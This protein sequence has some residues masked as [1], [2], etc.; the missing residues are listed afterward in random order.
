M[1]PLLLQIGARLADVA[2]LAA[3]RPSLAGEGSEDAA[4]ASA[5]Q[6]GEREIIAEAF[7]YKTD[8]V[9][10]LRKAICAVAGLGHI[11][12]LSEAGEPLAGHHTVEEAGLGHRSEVRVLPVSELTIATG[13]ADCDLRIWDAD[14]GLC[15]D[16]LRAHEEPIH[17]T[18]FSHAGGTLATASAD[19]TAK[20]WSVEDRSSFRTLSDH[21]DWVQTIVFSPDDSKLLTASMDCSAKLWDI[22]TG[23]CTRTVNAEL[24]PLFS[25]AFAPCGELAVL[26]GAP[27]SNSAK[28]WDLR[29]PDGAGAVF[30]PDGSGGEHEDNVVDAQF[31]M[32]GSKVITGSQD[33]T[34]KLWDLR[35]RGCLWTLT[36]H[37]ATV[38]ATLFSFDGRQVLTGS[39]DRSLRLW[40]LQSREC[41]RTFTGHTGFVTSAA[42]APD[43]QSVASASRDATARL[44]DVKSGRCMHVLEGHRE[45]LHSVSFLPF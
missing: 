3:R 42:F 30:G 41:V 15:M 10:A 36:G 22:P 21:Q 7:V 6:G 5:E 25:A 19:G 26:A 8:T 4:A 31:S 33:G 9:L 2:T 13:S 40:D 27:A 17:W 38:T 43:G 32:D 34:A 20:L 14:A 1:A 44:W 24:C 11:S 37:N 23:I 35:S 18:A 16:K 28:L 29:S 12:L 45:K 39:C